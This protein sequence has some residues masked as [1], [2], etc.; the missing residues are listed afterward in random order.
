[1]RN[2]DLPTAESYASADDLNDRRGSETHET[3]INLRGKYDRVDEKNYVVDG[4]KDEAQRGPEQQTYAVAK[5]PAKE[6]PHACEAR[7]R[8]QTEEK[9][10][11][12]I[13]CRHVLQIRNA[14]ASV[15]IFVSR[16]A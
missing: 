11:E 3:Q 14:S 8:G 6:Q 16:S 10:S 4:K 13:H 15:C 7:E 1:M 5:I 9:K 12:C 2:G